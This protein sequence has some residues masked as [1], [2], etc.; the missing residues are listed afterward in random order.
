MPSLNVLPLAT[1][2]KC[3]E[4]Q[5]GQRTGTCVSAASEAVPGSQC[6]TFMPVRG[7]LKMTLRSIP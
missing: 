1:L 4:A 3:S 7:H 6:C 2:T 5:A